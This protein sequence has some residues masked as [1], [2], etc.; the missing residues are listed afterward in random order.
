M[1][2]ALEQVYNYIESGEKDTDYVI[3]TDSAYV[4]N[5]CNDW[6]FRWQ[7]NGWRNSK[8]VEVENIDLMKT[9]YNYLNKNFST[10]QGGSLKDRVEILKVK[11]HAGTIG[12][13]LVDALAQNS[14]T[15][16]NNLIQMNIN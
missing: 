2:A 10:C 12:N 6:I 5:T 13:E 11:G 7:A 16:W 9:L 4:C 14:K 15:K 1:I 8:K 3:Y